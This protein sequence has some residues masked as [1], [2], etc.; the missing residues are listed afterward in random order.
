[1]KFFN[2]FNRSKQEQPRPKKRTIGMS[3]GTLVS[4]DTSMEVS[5][6]YRG[7]IYISSQI[8]KLPWEVKDRDNNNIINN[9][10]YLLNVSPNYEMTA[11]HF[12]L[13]MI[14]CAI[15]GGNGYAEIER[16]VDGRPTALW[17]LNPKKVCARRDVNDKLWYEVTQGDPQGNTVYLEPKDILIFRNFHTKD[18]LEG[19]G[20]VGYAMNTLGISLGADTFAN[21]LFSNGG[22]P[23]G[24]LEAPGKMSDEAYNR[25]VESWKAGFGGKK[26][27]STAI[28]EDG[29]KYSPISHS[30]DVLQFLE[31]RKFSVI[32]IARF[33][34]VPPTMLF[35]SDSAKFNNVEHQNLQVVVDVLDAWAKNL[36]SEVDMKLLNGQRGGV[37]TELDLYEVFRGDA[38]TR[39]TY[40]KNMMQIGAMSPNEVRAKEGFAPHPDGDKY[41]IASNNLSPLNRLDEIIDSQIEGKEPVESSSSEEDTAIDETEAEL[42]AKVLEYFDRRLT[43]N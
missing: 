3:G 30:P 34:G 19:Q 15:V 8:A 31:S 37:H 12:K 11:F 35:D 7:V 32:E 24:T 5:A 17:P 36:E 2:F 29:V 38:V 40:F 26:T 21:A 43:K 42:N 41:F 13:F 23:S 25:L 1:M 39:S 28:L 33:L 22:M 18:G 4:E 10:H 16:T 14:Q 9:I 6:F 27:G 20:L